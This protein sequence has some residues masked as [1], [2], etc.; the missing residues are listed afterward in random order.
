MSAQIVSFPKAATPTAPIEDDVPACFRWPTAF[1]GLPFVSPNV[2]EY[3]GPDSLWSLQPTGDFRKDGDAAV[4]ETRIQSDGKAQSAG[5]API[6]F[7]A[8]CG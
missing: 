4:R 1:V 8:L 7:A 5:H 2:S 3:G 6:R